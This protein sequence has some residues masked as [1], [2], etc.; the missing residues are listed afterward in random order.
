MI[1]DVFLEDM[2]TRGIEVVRNS[3]FMS[4][5][6]EGS[7]NY[8]VTTCEDLTTGKNRTIRSKYVVGCDGAHSRVRKSMASVEMVGES[9]KAAWGVLDGSRDLPLLPG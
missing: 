6:T 7:E 3:P 8:I 2:K 5:T 1:E 9:G 4:C